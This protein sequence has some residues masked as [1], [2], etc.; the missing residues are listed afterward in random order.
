[1]KNKNVLMPTNWNKLSYICIQVY[2][3]LMK[4][5][6]TKT[7]IKIKLNRSIDKINTKYKSTKQNY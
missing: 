7:E 3:N 4:F 2:K 6:K 5:I 1:M